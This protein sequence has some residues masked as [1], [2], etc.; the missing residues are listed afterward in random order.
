MS[1]FLKYAFLFFI[2][3]FFLDGFLF[4]IGS[5]FGWV[6]ELIYRRFIHGKWVNPGFLVGPCLP[7]YGSGLC[8]LTFI[9]NCAI[10]FKFYNSLL[11]ILFMGIMMTFIEL[12]G[13]LVFLK[14]GDIKL[15]DYSN[16][17][18]NYKGI[19]CPMFSL[20]WTFLSA[21]Y[22][23]FLAYYVNELVTWFANNISFS[24]IVGIFYGIFIIDFVYSTKLLIKI[25]M[26]ANDNGIIVKYEEL[27]L[28]IKKASLEA[29]EKYSFLFPF[30][31]FEKVVK[32][33]LGLLS[34]FKS[35]IIKKK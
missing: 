12:I 6:L 18:G 7:I 19:I 4:F 32:Q 27:K 1:I 24:F 13:G 15:W 28:K 22:Y 17:W 20:I 21:I 10:D 35:K 5:T 3:N 25:R 14:L 26:F 23:F 9:Y 2:Y 11:I 8:V 34:F 33:N 16:E 30:K 29:K 31:N